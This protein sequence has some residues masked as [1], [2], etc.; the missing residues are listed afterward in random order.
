LQAEELYREHGD[1]LTPTSAYD[2][3]YT[4]TGGDEDQACDAFQAQAARIEAVKEEMAESDD[5]E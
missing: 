5:G 2:L 1:K 4:M 3:T